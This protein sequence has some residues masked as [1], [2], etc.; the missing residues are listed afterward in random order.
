[1]LQDHQDWNY[2][3]FKFTILKPVIECI[4]VGKNLDMKILQNIVR[5]VK[6]INFL[7]CLA[8]KSELLVLYKALQPEC[9]C[10]NLLS[11]IPLNNKQTKNLIISLL[12][13][14]HTQD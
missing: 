6:E 8:Q 9:D 13:M 14:A 11:R 5:Q 2:V 3:T 12:E 1:M 7:E 10:V 4:K